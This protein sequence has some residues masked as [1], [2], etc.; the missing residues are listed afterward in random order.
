[1]IGGQDVD[2]ENYP[3]QVSLQYLSTHICGAS[4]IS[5]KYIFTAAHCTNE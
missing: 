5:E 2:I 4:V 3:Y 1:M